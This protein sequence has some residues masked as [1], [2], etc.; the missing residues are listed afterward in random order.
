MANRDWTPE[1]TKVIIL[2]LG[3]E[4][5]DD[6][7][8]PIGH[9]DAVLH[10]FFK[11]SGIP[12]K[13]NVHFRNEEGDRD[14]MLEFLP[15]FLADSTEDSLL[16]FYYAGHG[17]EPEESDYDYD[18]SFCHP[19]ENSLTMGDV[20]DAIEENF[21]G[22]SVLFI[23]D[24]CQSGNVARFAATAD[25]DYYYA[26]LTSALATESSTGAWTFT[27]CLLEALTGK[28]HIDQ[29]EDGSISLEELAKYAKEQMKEVENQRSDFGYSE[30]FDI[31]MR[32]AVVSE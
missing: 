28:A 12:D 18:L 23:V 32:L 19:S 5:W 24:C 31:E 26:G 17:E 14:T 15:D 7:S 3:L 22:W 25:S 30:G 8:D 2:G 6:P 16:I 29:D 21:E 27:D 20:V 9:R 10:K 4:D 13:N 11:K 1:N